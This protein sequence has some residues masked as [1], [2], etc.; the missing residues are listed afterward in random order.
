MRRS[1]CLIFWPLCSLSQVRRLIPWALLFGVL[2][3]SGCAPLHEGVTL[4]AG[5][6]HPPRILSVETS[7]AYTIELEFDKETELIPGRFSVSPDLG[8]PVVS[9]S[10]GTRLHL[11]F[12]EPTVAGVE[13]VLDAG[14]QDMHGNSLAF[15]ARVYGHNSHPPQL[16]INELN[17]R[18]STANPERVELVSLT[19]GNLA[20]IALYNGSPSNYNS[21]FI[22]PPVEIEAG[23]FIVVHFRPEESP[24]EVNETLAQDE[25]GGSRAVDHAWDYWIT[26]GGGL[27]SNNG[28]VA[29]YTTP[30]GKMID[31]VIWSNRTSESDELYR[32]FGTRKMMEWVDE[33]MGDGGW[34]IAGYE[35]A[36]EDAVD[37]DGSTATRSLN[38]NS[39]S[40]DTDTRLDWHIVPT[41]GAS[42]GAPNS[43]D[44]HSP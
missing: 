44:V 31:A 39:H 23:D 19:A 22:F 7:G 24:E 17:P 34:S 11:R 35:I 27:P 42:F 4:V 12:P 13:Y 43:D 16:L 18:A 25:S 30:R 10:G 5:D 8:E 9:G 38:R 1:S 36:P 3:L 2:M 41:S 20:G 14:V 32:G 37:P 6:F 21:R 33:V 29:L 15:L 28:V 26:E 40:E